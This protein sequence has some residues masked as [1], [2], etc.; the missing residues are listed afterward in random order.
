MS[1]ILYLLAVTATHAEAQPARASGEQGTPG[2]IW[3]SV[4]DVVGKPLKARVDLYDGVSERPRTI[5]LPKGEGEWPCPAGTYSAHTSIYDWGAPIMIDIQTV[6][7]R[8][9]QTT[10]LLVELVE[11]VAGSHTVS[12]FDRD[13][14]LVIDRVELKAGTDPENPGSYPQAEPVIFESPVIANE[15]GWYCGELHARS[16]YGGGTETVAQLVKR[17][18]RTG[19]DFLAITDRNS[20]LSCMDP[21]FQSKKIVLI[22]GMEWG[23]DERGVALVYGPETFPEP[24]G[25]LPDARGICQRVKAQGG[26]FAV[27]HPCFALAPWQWGLNSV[28]AIEVWCR[29]WRS[30]PP[31]GL[32]RLDNEYKRRDPNTGGLVHTLSKAA[33]TRG[34]SANGQAEQFYNLEL[35]RGLQACIIAGGLSAHPDVPLG[36]PLTYVYA[37]QKSVLGILNGLWEGR[38]FVTSGGKDHPRLFLNADVDIDGTVDAGVGDIVG[39]LGKPIRFEAQVVNGAGTRLQ[40]LRNGDPVQVRS[41]EADGKREV[42]ALAYDDQPTTYSYYQARLT[43]AEAG[44]G[45]GPGDVVALTSPIYVQK[46]IVVDPEKTGG[47]VMIRLDKPDGQTG[48]APDASAIVGTPWNPLPNQKVVEDPMQPQTNR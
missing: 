35:A 27:A 22:P 24:A 47:E 32:A 44:P 1:G 40:I 21:D 9:G 41:V 48:E 14:D 11:G 30:V 18:E 39:L 34:L 20:M 13:G 23:N 7:V 28:N 43:R 36:E 42:F 15:A 33:S 46:I 8:P 17:A 6:R 10:D 25:T 3:V 45:F 26:V 12:D 31:I 29:D 19:L 38:T 5:R 16:K 37:E 2:S 4:A